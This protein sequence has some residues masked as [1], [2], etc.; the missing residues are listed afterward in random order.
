MDASKRASFRKI[1]SFLD[2]TLGEDDSMDTDQAVNVR[3]LSNYRRLRNVR[4][5]NN[6]PTLQTEDVA[7]HSFYVAILATAL[8]EDYNHNVEQHNANFHPLDVENTLDTVNVVQVIRQALFHDMEEAFT[9]DIPWNVKHHSEKTRLAI[10]QCVE[11]KLDVV[12][13]HTNMPIN[14]HQALILRAKDGLPGKFVNIADNLEGAWYC[15][16]ELTM[17]NGYMKELFLKYL[18]V[19]QQDSFVFLLVRFSP[20]FVEIM[21]MFEAMRSGL[22]P[23]S[24][25]PWNSMILN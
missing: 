24:T 2:R 10:Q 21:K 23:K 15:Y 14:S 8:A 16:D 11:A 20:L 9:S 7:Q 12:F 3:V 17:G 6:L 5:A 13:H 1:F 22:L 19:I 25:D 18:Q 4:R